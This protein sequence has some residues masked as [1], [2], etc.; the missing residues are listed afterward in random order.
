MAQRK[1]SPASKFGGRH[2][3]VIGGSMA[4]MLASRVLA[5]H[6]ERVTLIER[7]RLPDKPEPRKGLPQE[8]QAHGLLDK[9]VEIL[10][11]FFPGLFEQLVASGSNIVDMSE[12]TWFRGGIWQARTQPGLRIYIQTRTLLDATVRSHLVR[13]PNLH[14]LDDCEAVRPLVTDDRTA[15]RG[16]E[17]R[18]RHQ[19]A[20]EVLEADVVVDASG[21]GSRMPRWLEDLGLPRVQETQLRIDVGYA[22]RRVRLPK[23]LVANWK[24]LT[25]YPKA[26]HEKRM[27][28]LAPVEGGTWLCTQAGFLG[29][30][31]PTDDAGFLEFARTLP[32]PH[33]YELLRRAE[34]LTPV[35]AHKFPADMRRHYERLPLPEGLVV[36]GDALCSFNPL[37]GQGMTVAAL[38]AVTLDETLAALP[39]GRLAGLSQRFHKQAAAMLELPWIMATSEDLNYPAVEGPRPLWWKLMQGYSGRL[40]GHSVRDSLISTTFS[41]VMHMRAS[42]LVMISPQMMLRALRSA[43]SEGI[44]TPPVMQFTEP[45]ATPASTVA[46]AG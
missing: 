19:E 28:A 29:D 18:R 38:A 45:S 34:P 22:S 46:N 17:V 6:F 7:D 27:G 4:G 30:I 13:Q 21:R 2:A 33:I 8:Q 36:L 32:Q 1:P 24:N 43:P 5:S 23:N 44:G 40:Q 39:P 14:I 41:N 31:P 10:E 15:I 35:V 3:V 11:G 20:S 25:I 42:P 26:P 9:A 37:Y 12:V 16:V